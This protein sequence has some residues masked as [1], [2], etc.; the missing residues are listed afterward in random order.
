MGRH[1]FLT[2]SFY[3][4]LTEECFELDIGYPGNDLNSQPGN[5]NYA[6]GEGRRDSAKECQQLCQQTQGCLFF[7]YRH[8]SKEC[9]LKSEDSGRSTQNGAISGKN[10]CEGILVYY[11]RIPP[12]H[13]YI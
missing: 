13:M 12:Y 4:S 7:T 11:N 2:V 8:A 9:W 1:F 5:V 3:F 6:L 10:Y